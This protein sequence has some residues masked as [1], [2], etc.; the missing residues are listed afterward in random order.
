MLAQEIVDQC[1]EHNIL[2]KLVCV[3]MDNA[4]VNG[5]VAD[6]LSAE[7]EDSLSTDALQSLGMF[8]HMTLV[9]LFSFHMT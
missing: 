3:M 8:H 2:R 4:S 7:T 9:R 5:R 6:F 1:N